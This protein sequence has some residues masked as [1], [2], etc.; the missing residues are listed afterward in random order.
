MRVLLLL[1][2]GISLSFGAI[3]Q[4]DSVYTQAYI[5]KSTKFAWLTFGGDLLMLS[6]GNTDFAQNGN[7]ENTSFG[8]TFI[9]RLTIGGMHFWGHADFYVSFPILSISQAPEGFSDITYRQGIET[10][11]RIY[12][13]KLQPNRLSP[14]VGI[15]FR[16]LDYNQEVE[17]S[18]YKHGFPMYER[19]IAPLEFGLTYT[20][21]KHHI[22]A[23]FY[24]QRKNRID[25]FINPGMIGTTNFNPYSFRLSFLRYK[26]T[27]KS[28]RNPKALQQ[29]NAMHE[30]LKKE[31]KLSSWYLGIGPSAGLQISKS[32]YLEL[33]QP[34]LYNDFFGGFTP[35]ITFGR[36]F[37]QPDINVGIAFRTIGDELKGFDTSIKLRRYSYM[38][39]GSKY[40]FNYLGFVPFVGV[41]G[42]VEQLSA[43]VN[44]VDYRVTKSAIGF[45]AGW[46]IRVTKTGTSLLR[47]NI[48]WV[49]DLHLDIDGDK[50]MFDH[51]ELNFIQWV[52][53][54]GR[55]KVYDKY[56]KG[57]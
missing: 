51:L 26:D 29:L 6:G 43:N 12:P 50:M 30:V 9:P 42:S 35:D 28:M 52:H 54:I 55:K 25:H 13:W 34:E 1:I 39:E 40:L 49:P 46:D 37:A 18:N 33:N 31:N 17:G 19:M 56:R 3:A 5:D 21:T 20:T 4:A 16:T 53:F 11:A 36:F 32:P 10:G 23:A 38:I 41:T 27:D 47:T 15:S 45:V 24:Y 7:V 14:Y 48:R 57:A 22:S 44:G 2:L 8:T